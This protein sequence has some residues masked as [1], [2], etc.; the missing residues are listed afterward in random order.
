MALSARSPGIDDHPGPV[1]D[2]EENNGVLCRSHNG[3][4]WSCLRPAAMKRQPLCWTTV[5]G[6]ASIDTLSSGP[7][8]HLRC[9]VEPVGDDYLCRIHGGDRH[10]GAV[11]LSEWRSTR[12]TTECLVVSGHKERDIAV[13]AAR[14]LCAASRRSVACVAGIHFDSLSRIE[15][16][17]IVEAVHALTR[18]AAGR[19]EHGRLDREN[20]AA[21]ER[22][23]V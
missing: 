4:L 16:E 1:R 11:A 19:L 9:D 3:P 17:A 12:A 10:I 13:H 5:I 8:W 18:Q 2:V 7:P 23:Q 15:I 22:G 6:R 21:A 14:L 20:T